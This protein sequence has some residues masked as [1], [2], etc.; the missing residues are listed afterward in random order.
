MINSKLEIEHFKPDSLP[1]FWDS[2]LTLFSASLCFHVWESCLGKNQSKFENP[3]LAR[4]SLTASFNGRNDSFSHAIL[5]DL[6]LRQ[7]WLSLL[8][9][10]QLGTR[11]G[12]QEQKGS[13]KE[14]CLTQALKTQG[15]AFKA[16]Q[17]AVELFL[18]FIY[19]W[20]CWVLAA[21]QASL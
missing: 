10:S 20:L 19:F 15:L 11:A 18:I 14:G 7:R 2:D 1:N 17:A 12:S 4:I 8:H 5:G 21:T 13:G 9:P 16:L 3:A 6:Y